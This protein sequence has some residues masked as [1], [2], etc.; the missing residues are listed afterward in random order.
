M[1]NDGFFEFGEINT[2]FTHT[3]THTQ[4]CASTCTHTHTH[5]HKY[6]H[7]QVLQCKMMASLN[8]VKQTYTSQ[9]HAHTH[10]NKHVQAHVHTHTHK[11]I[12]KYKHA[13]VHTPPLSLSHT[14]R[15]TGN[16]AKSILTD[17][18]FSND[19]ARGGL[20]FWG[21]YNHI[22]TL[23]YVKCCCNS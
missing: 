9:T 7:A 16:V 15:T 2:Y 20:S 18:A 8:L 5:I 21:Q 11:H 1:Q 23:N 12:H 19:W 13:Q 10:T 3:H 14:Q 22:K 6:K 17:T 4:T